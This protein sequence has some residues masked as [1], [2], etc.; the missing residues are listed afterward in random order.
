MVWQTG[1][2]V[3]QYEIVSQLG[4]GGMATVYKAY[5][6]HLDRHVAI[7]VMHA[8][9]QDDPS[10]VTRFNR[11]AQIVARLQHPHIVPVYDFA[12]HEN[13]SYFVMKYVEGETLKERLQRN[14]LTV[15]EI[16]QI[17]TAVASALDYA[18]SRDILH[19]DVKPSNIVIE[20]DGT[21]YLADFGLARLS[22]VG[23]STMSA[24]MVLGTPHYISP[25]QA[26]GQKELDGRTDVYSFGVVLYELF[27]G[28]VPFSAENYYSIIN[29]HINTPVPQPSLVNPDIPETVS[30]V[31]IKAMSK[32]PSHRYNT[33]T[34]VVQDL[35]Q[36][37][38]IGRLGALSQDR[39][40]LA[41]VSLAQLRQAYEETSE[42]DIPTLSTPILNRGVTPSKT[43]LLTTTPSGFRT[44]TVVQ[45]DDTPRKRN[46][47]VYGGLGVFL[48]VCLISIFVVLGAIDN[49]TQLAQILAN[50]AQSGALI[51][52]AT[53]IEDIS[54]YEDIGVS[55]ERNDNPVP[56]YQV[57]S[58]SLD[59][60]LTLQTENPNDII[61]NLI[62]A[63]AYWA[64]GNTPQARQAIADGIDKNPSKEI[65][66]LSAAQI[67]QKY[68]DTVA[69]AGY[70]LMVSSSSE[71]SPLISTV[72]R[73][74][75][76]E[77]LYNLVPEL[78]DVTLNEIVE[79]ILSDDSITRLELRAIATSDSALL[80]LARGNSLNNNLVVAQQL[81]NRIPDEGTLYP[82]KQ[83][84]TAELY[85]ARNNSQ[86]ALE[87]LTRLAEDSTI[88]VWIR[89]RAET[90]QEGL[91]KD[92]S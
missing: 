66:L 71:K 3:G 92:N 28:R 61:P 65:Y 52:L 54:Q 41:E 47:W 22:T 25:E 33:A 2:H 21:P 34:E 27:V 18:H 31:L 1:L 9:F 62:L 13:Q 49:V 81:L 91:E 77:T 23:Q 17:M 50:N 88:P 63:D 4:S 36:A 14:L 74:Y 80:L 35:K 7:K 42:D 40:T 90:L 11:E 44:A 68:G 56:L 72:L 59:E 6:R 51:D 10:F 43:P 87:I 84:I 30:N 15:D 86:Q 89:N 69:Q 46:L 73:P 58:I 64:E 38:A 32:R 19:R 29:D 5:H 75:I 12:E 55:I 85:I 83:L 26:K 70:L 24:D 79:D 60:A 82:E 37:I 57:P 16:I 78:K 20:K 67:A 76:G 8:T 53:S 45:A 39:G 48:G